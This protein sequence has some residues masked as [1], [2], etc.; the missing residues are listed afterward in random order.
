MPTIPPPLKVPPAG[1]PVST[2]G[3]SSR[4]RSAILF[5]LTKGSGFTIMVIVL[6]DGHG[7]LIV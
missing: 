7:V 5:I 3:A 2:T 6:F 4:Q 1:L